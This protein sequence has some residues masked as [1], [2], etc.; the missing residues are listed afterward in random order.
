[1][2]QIF[3]SLSLPST[4]FVFSRA[5]PMPGKFRGNLFNDVYMG[6]LNM[7]IVLPMLLE[8]VTFR[9]IYNKL[10]GSNRVYAIQFARVLIISA[11][12]L[13]FTVK[14]SKL[15]GAGCSIPAGGGHQL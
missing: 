8:S 1:M 7:F 15:E 6:L 5:M 12:L 11:P 3:L 4:T 14:V 13:V 10:L 2:N 9:F